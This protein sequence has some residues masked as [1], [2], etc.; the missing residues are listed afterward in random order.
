MSPN[1]PTLEEEE[2]LKI[3]NI[4]FNSLDVI[5]NQETII[6][7]I[8]F[9]KRVFPASEVLQEEELDDEVEDKDT[10][11][12][13][14][15]GVRTEVTAE[16]QRLNLLLLRAGSGRRIGT[17]LLTDARLTFFLSVCLKRFR[18]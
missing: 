4:Q 6:E 14:R 17:A 10:S 1:C 2:H 9:S 12:T 15:L 8:G 3:L 18:D 5:A 11:D 16:F 13:E 7:L